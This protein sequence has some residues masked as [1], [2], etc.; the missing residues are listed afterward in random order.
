ML[1]TVMG[2][3]LGTWALAIGLA[4]THQSRLVFGTP[5][6]LRRAPPG[7]APGQHETTPVTLRSQGQTLA[8]WISQPRRRH[9][10]VFRGAQ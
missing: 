10:A 6:T 2:A 9:R 7:P 5:R 4:A 8:G 3:A 1:L